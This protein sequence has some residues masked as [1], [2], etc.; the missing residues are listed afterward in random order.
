M[1]AL[2]SGMTELS[3]EGERVAR[4]GHRDRDLTLGHLSP[5]GTMAGAR[6]GCLGRPL[7]PEPAEEGGH[8]L[9]RALENEPGAEPA[10]LAQLVGTA[11]PAQQDHQNGFLSPGARGLSLFHGVV[12]FCDLQGSL[13]SLRRLLSYG[14]V[15]T[16]TPPGDLGNRALV[17]KLRHLWR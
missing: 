1:I 3:N 12:S 10:E 9:D 15:R 14:G 16:A 13:W 4:L 5:A 8:V 17:A 6:A 2:V 7:A 11:D